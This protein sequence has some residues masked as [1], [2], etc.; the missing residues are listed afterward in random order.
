[1]VCIDKSTPGASTWTM[2]ADER[3]E[4][5]AG[6]MQGGF[7][8]AFCD[9]AMG[10]AAV[11]FAGERKVNVANAEL[12]VSM[13]RAV[14]TGSHLTCAARVS[15]GGRNVAFVEADVTDQSGVLLARA[16]STYI[17]KDRK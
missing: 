14:T 4:N 16:T 5:P 3:F 13:L 6:I 11:T 7:I 12:K 2:R 1:M 15:S 10:A 17:Y 9:S 8:A